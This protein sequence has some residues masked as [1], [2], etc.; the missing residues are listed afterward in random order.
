M[1]IVVFAVVLAT[2]IWM[3]IDAKSLQYNPENHTGIGKSSPLNWLFGGLLLWVI[4]FPMYLVTRPKYLAEVRG[5]GAVGANPTQP[6][7]AKTGSTE[8]KQKTEGWFSWANHNKEWAA[9]MTEMS[10]RGRRERGLP[11]SLIDVVE[12]DGKEIFRY[13]VPENYWYEGSKEETKFLASQGAVYDY[14]KQASGAGADDER[15]R[16]MALLTGLIG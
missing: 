2:S 12:R 3:Y 7:K 15:A 13:Y 4:V 10:N 1:D 14:Q 6:Q 16:T 8:F 11:E 9:E 5:T